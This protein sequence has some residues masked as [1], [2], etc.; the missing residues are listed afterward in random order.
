MGFLN[1]RIILVLLLFT[2]IT[3]DSCISQQLD[4]DCVLVDNGTTINKTMLLQQP[5]EY[6]AVG[7][8]VFSLRSVSPLVY[9]FLFIY[10]IF[11]VNRLTRKLES[12]PGFSVQN[13]QFDN[14]TD[15]KALSSTDSA[16]T[17]APLSV[18]AR[19][20]RWLE[21]LD[22][23]IK[24]ELSNTLLKPIDLAEHMGVCERQ[25]Q[26]KLKE[27]KGI[28]PAKYLK[29]TRLKVGYEHLKSGDYQTISEVAYAVGYTSPNNFSRAFKNHFGV[30]PNDLI[31]TRVVI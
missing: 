26:R 22:E 13:Q 23:L 8:Q 27:L 9:C 25:L 1:K 3:A 28:S 6:G 14:G 20:V 2:V 7:Q 16:K 24:N 31:N 11:R 4:H 19:D 5:P 12:T 29:Q 15:S 30:R 17:Q 18:T 10:T 21:K